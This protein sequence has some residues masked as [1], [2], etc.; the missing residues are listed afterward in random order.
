MSR[1]LTVGLAVLMTFS[2]QSLNAR[3]TIDNQRR[4]TLW[5]LG[6]CLISVLAKVLITIFELSAIREPLSANVLGL[7]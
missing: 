4:L 1:K 6:H 5:Q 3:E 2:Q 7:L